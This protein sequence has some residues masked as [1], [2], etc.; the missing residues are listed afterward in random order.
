MIDEDVAPSF[1][2]L[3]IRMWQT[4]QTTDAHKGSRIHYMGLSGVQVQSSA[5]QP[6]SLSYQVDNGHLGSQLYLP[7]WTENPA[8][9]LSSSYVASVSIYL[10]AYLAIK[11]NL[12]SSA[13]CLLPRITTCFVTETKSRLHS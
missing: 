11:C 8:G 3:E 13:G 4:S 12:D 1:I 6:G 5:A 2:F 10:V 9:F 7:R